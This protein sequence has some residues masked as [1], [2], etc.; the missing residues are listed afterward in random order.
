MQILKCP[1]WTK[2][3]EE[4]EVKNSYQYVFEL[5]ETLEQTLQLAQQ[6]MRRAQTRYK[7]Y[8]D[9]KT[10]NRYFSPGDLVLLLLPSNN[11]KLLMQ[12]KGPYT[13]VDVVN[14]NDY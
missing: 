10:R 7:H 12:W 2:E 9:K 11:N 14:L 6:E 5:R 8:Y 13:V 1:L 3:C 4:D